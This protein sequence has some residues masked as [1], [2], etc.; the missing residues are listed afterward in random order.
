VDGVDEVLKL[1]VGYGSHA[2]LEDFAP[3]LAEA[4]GRTV[5]VRVDT[6]SAWRVQTDPS[7]ATVTDTRADNTD[8]KISGPPTAVLRWLWSRD[9]TPTADAPSPVRVDGDEEAVK[10]FRQLLVASTQ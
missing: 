4:K 6:G 2:W 9:S 3:L 1:F 5:T 8:A 10:E 7:G